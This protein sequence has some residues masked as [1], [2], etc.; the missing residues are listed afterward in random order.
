MGDVPQ[1][2]HDFCYYYAPWLYIT[3]ATLTGNAAAGQKDIAVPD[4][5]AFQANMPVEIKDNVHSEWNEVDSVLVNV[6]TLKTNLSHTYYT[7]KGAVAEHP[8]LAFG[9]TCFQAAQYPTWAERRERNH[10]L[11]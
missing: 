7:A 2:Y 5:T 9:K 1:A 6:V 8:D 4:G 11:Y 3:S 10:F